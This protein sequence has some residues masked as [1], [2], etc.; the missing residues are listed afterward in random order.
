MTLQVV[1]PSLTSWVW[2]LEP[3]NMVGGENELLQAGLRP[4]R[5]HHVFT[6]THN[7]YMWKWAGFDYWKVRLVK[8]LNYM[9]IIC[10]FNRSVYKHCFFF[11]FFF[12]KERMYTKESKD[13]FC[14]FTY[15]LI[16]IFGDWK[17]ISNLNALHGKVANSS[18][19]LLEKNM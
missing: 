16:H 18:L 8:D 4:A 3:W 15:W 17:M 1:A 6:H 9:E 13:Q 2:S 19:N 11:V 14:L 5:V 7:T 12:N 10:V